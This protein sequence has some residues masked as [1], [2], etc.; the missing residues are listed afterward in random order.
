MAKMMVENILQSWDTHIPG[1]QQKTDS[2]FDY[3]TK[4]FSSKNTALV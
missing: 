2:F 4:E 1:Q 3:V